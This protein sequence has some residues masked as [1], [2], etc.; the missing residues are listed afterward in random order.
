EGRHKEIRNVSQYDASGRFAPK[1]APLGAVAF[2]LGATA[3]ADDFIWM[4]EPDEL[5][6]LNETRL[7]TMGVRPEDSRAFRLNGQYNL[8]RQ[9]RI[10][11]ALDALHD[12]TGRPEFVARAAGALVDADAQFYTES[13]LAAE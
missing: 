3:T 5:V 1:L 11:T 6:T 8:T 4:K 10:V 9:V 2:A 12:V 7:R 13:A